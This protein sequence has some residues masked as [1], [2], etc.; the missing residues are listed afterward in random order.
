M[1]TTQCG[2]DS[3]KKTTNVSRSNAFAHCARST[4]R[5]EEFLEIQQALGCTGDGTPFNRYV[6]TW[7]L[8]RERVIESIYA[9]WD[10]LSA[11]FQSIKNQVP[12]EQRLK[13]AKLCKIFL[14]NFKYC[15]LM[16]LLP[17]VK[18]FEKINKLFQVNTNY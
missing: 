3:D 9:N 7:W 14:D 16:F 12:Q 15:L 6:E 17:I 13:V 5:R 11:Y 4:L 18:Q 1:L 2:V 10:T 8:V